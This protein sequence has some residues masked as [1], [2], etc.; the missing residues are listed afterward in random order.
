MTL[1]YKKSDEQDVQI[2]IFELLPLNVIEF[3]A[4]NDADAFR[5]AMSLPT[6][7]QA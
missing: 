2:M 6:E 3:V 4:L 7:P 5:D 1:N